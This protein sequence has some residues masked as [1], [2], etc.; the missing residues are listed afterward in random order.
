MRVAAYLSGR[1][2][3]AFYGTAKPVPFVQRRFFPQPV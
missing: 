3:K 1:R 2:W